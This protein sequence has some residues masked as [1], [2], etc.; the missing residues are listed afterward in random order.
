MSHQEKT[1]FQKLIDREIPCEVI[2]EDDTV[3]CFKDISPQAPVHVLLIPKKPIPRIQEA[4]PENAAILGHL[5]A[6]IPSITQKLG[7]ADKG[8]RIVIN[9]GVDGGETVP[10]MHI[11]IL[12]GRPLTWPPG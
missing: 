12:G 8:Y 5:M 4:G 3:F 11:H 2:F 10:H 9:N 6:Q 1:L 7:V